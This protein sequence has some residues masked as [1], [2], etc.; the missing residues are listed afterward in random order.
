MAKST[1]HVETFLEEFREQ[2]IAGLRS[3]GAILEAWVSQQPATITEGLTLQE[4]VRVLF[5]IVEEGTS[6]SKV[7]LY[8][9]LSHKEPELIA[10]LEQRQQNSKMTQTEQ[11]WTMENTKQLELDEIEK[12]KH[13]LQTERENIDR[14][15]QLA[16][17]EMDVMKSMREDTEKQKQELDNKLQR[18]KNAIRELEVMKTEI[19]LKKKDIVK[20]IR[21][22][23]RKTEEISRMKKETEH[24]GQEKTEGQRSEQEVNTEDRYDKH[25]IREQHVDIAKDKI[26]PKESQFEVDSMEKITTDKR[27][28]NMK[29]VTAGVEEISKERDELE[30]NKT[31]IQQQKEEVEQKLE[32]TMT[33]ILT[34]GKIK[35]TIEKANEEINNTQ[36]ELLKTQRKMEE[37]KEEVHKY[38]DKVASMNAQIS[39]WILT[40]SVIKKTFLANV[41]KL[42]EPQ[43]ETRRKFLKETLDFPTGN[44]GAEDDITKT[45]VSLQ[46]SITLEDQ[47]QSEGIE[48]RE[49]G[50]SDQK[51]FFAV[52]LKEEQNTFLQ[53]Q[54]EIHEETLIDDYKTELK[55]NQR[56]YEAVEK[57]IY[58]LKEREEKITEQ[59][60]YAIK[61]MEEKSREI[62]RVIMEIN[63]L[64]IQ[65][66]EL[67]PVLE[68]TVKESGN[69]EEQETGMLKET[70]HRGI[71]K[72]N[73]DVL[74]YEINKYEVQIQKEES[75]IKQ[76]IDE[77]DLI[78]VDVDK[79]EKSQVS[80]KKVQTDNEE[81]HRD[82][83]KKDTGSADIQKLRAEICRTQEILTSVKLE[84]QNQ[85]ENSNTDKYHKEES[86]TEVLIQEIKQFQEFLKMV[87]TA[88]RQSEMHFKE[89]MSNIKL[90]K[91]VARKQ[92][93]KLDQRLENTLRERDELDILKIKMQRQTDVFKKKLEK[94]SKVKST[95]EKI[96]MEETKVKHRQLEDLSNKIDAI[97]Q[98]LENT[99][100]KKHDRTEMDTEEDK[101][102][103]K[104]T[105][106]ETKDKIITLRLDKEKLEEDIKMILD[107]LDQKTRETEQLKKL[108]NEVK[109]KRESEETEILKQIQVEKENVSR[110]IQQAEAERHESNCL[111]DDIERQKQELDDRAQMIKRETREM[112]LLKSELEIKKKEREHIFRKSLRR[113]EESDI[114]RN[115]I[116]REKLLR[117]VIKKE[118]RQLDQR[119]EKTMRD[120][121]ECEMLRKRLQQNE[122]E[123]AEEKQRIKDQATLIQVLREYQKQTLEKKLV[124]K[125]NME[126]EIPKVTNTV[127]D[128]QNMT[129]NMHVHL[130]I[131]RS[132]IGR[133]E[134]INVQLEKQKE[135]LKALNA[136]NRTVRDCM[137][138]IKSQKKMDFERIIIQSKA[139]MDELLQMKD[140][141]QKQKQELDNR[142]GTV[143]KEKRDMEVLMSELMLK[144]REHQQMIRKGIRKE[145]EVKQLW[146]EVKEEKEALKRETQK[147]RKEL[148]QK[149]ERIIR[150]SDELEIIRLKL[151]REKDESRGEIN[152]RKESERDIK[153]AELVLKEKQIKEKELL[154]Q[155]TEDLETQEERMKQETLHLELI[156]STIVEQ[157]HILKRD[158]EMEK[159]K[160][161]T[162]KYNL[163]KKK[164]Y[165]DCVFDNINTEKIMI[166]SLK[167]QVQTDI[168]KLDN[169]I[170]TMTLKEEEQKIKDEDM[171][172]L[173]QKLQNMEN[174]LQAEKEKLG[175]LREELN[176]QK[177]VVET[178]LK[179]ISGEREQL[180]HI[181]TDIEQE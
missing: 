124:K 170:N 48:E 180:I 113:K 10:N 50:Q 162:T 14:D 134:N 71:W 63:D 61:N 46:Q 90:M 12:N 119:Q 76:V 60:R 102:T 13:E 44:K 85:A 20:T 66:S 40:E 100:E 149:L 45:A 74:K 145:Q 58:M 117:S 108:I 25:E 32:H 62:K 15:K 140:D 146:T 19:E 122:E 105:G 9:I 138:R 136:E 125:V 79:Q 175:F 153:K 156:R 41:S 93:R 84:F 137:S 123:L 97:T 55:I 177:E 51:H 3:P 54:T 29:R 38:M 7:G 37:S 5:G 68:F 34:I 78:K 110:A 178:A 171:K 82:S 160:W 96:I 59:I 94:M 139:E 127:I 83:G 120:C 98:D 53:M 159:D 49:H 22:G 114:M 23:K 56:E 179:S 168:K 128:L 6:Q 8:Q 109:Q 81:I 30:I 24:D 129:Q 91:A 115:K 176:E 118:K 141:I 152:I 87:K 69:L 148:D 65:R 166:K 169:T 172:R 18:T 99:T 151:Q 157:L 86:E 52:D 144:K 89:E 106:K 103:K 158:I 142:L 101:L 164:E 17:A 161:E 39:R 150:E 11:N 111:R 31:K 2:I 131:I 155:K 27:E 35:T 121:D 167:L 77:S 1:E 75:K 57:Q 163:Q 135:W 130:E 104:R 116:Q 16:K 43:R 95:I 28:T 112:D 4:Q 154:K 173:K 36:E 143:K 67:E 33:A 147:R 181:K 88:I 174:N 126:K 21:M 70:E 73:T 47:H 132:D 80:K 42:Q 72:V 92:K 165:A 64:Q 133:L 26:Q 107:S